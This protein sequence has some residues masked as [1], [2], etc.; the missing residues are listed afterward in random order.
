MSLDALRGPMLDTLAKH[1]GRLATEKRDDVLAE[2]VTLVIG[3]GA[4]KS[5]DAYLAEYEKARRP[6][7]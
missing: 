1:L 4:E 5:A 6:V 2:V 7:A 3:R